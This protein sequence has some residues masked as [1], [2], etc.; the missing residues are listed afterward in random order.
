MRPLVR[1]KQLL[2]Y[3][4]PWCP[5]AWGRAELA[6]SVTAALTGHLI[7]GKHPLTFATE[8]AR[9]TGRR[10]AVPLNRARFGITLILRS[11]GIGAGDEVV[12]PA[13]ICESAVEAILATGARPAF[14]DVGED[15]NIFPEAVLR[16]LTSHT[17][18]VIVPHLFGRAA[19]IAG[20]ESALRETGIPVIDDAAQSFG[21]LCDGRPVGSFG[22]AAVVGCGAGKS[23]SGVA[24]SVLLTDDPRIHDFARANAGGAERPSEVFRRLASC[25]I[26]RRFRRQT[27]L[28][29]PWFRKHFPEPRH[30]PGPSPISNVDAA[31]AEC[32]LRTL[33]TRAQA[34]RRNS[35]QIAPLFADSDCR[36]LATFSR[37]DVALKLVVVL[38]PS[39]PSAVDAVEVMQAE[40]IECQPGY[41]PYPIANGD[42][43]HM[44]S[45]AE[46]T[47][48]NR[49][50]RSVLCIPVER[51]IR[52]EPLRRAIH[53]LLAQ[54]GADAVSRHPCS[55]SIDAQPNGERSYR[56]S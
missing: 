3:R 32:Q 23:L 5:P 21:A 2:A 53:R 29:E 33:E 52:P 37:T 49:L 45:S 36:V 54:R 41:V 18:C 35:A 26:W 38:P 50:W 9:L 48:T 13:Y 22:I 4:V 46:L 34:R 8:V 12:V 43:P 56:R 1:L 16:A 30:V 42:I 44:G 10:F 27:F 14:A 19:P 55:E 15:L 6:C 31:L 20:I 51:P 11:L 40:G 7:R 24:G 39:A 47:V 25:W 17:K 28:F